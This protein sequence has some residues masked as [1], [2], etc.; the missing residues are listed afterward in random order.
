MKC[1]KN[2]SCQ[3]IED[4]PLLYAIIIRYYSTI[5]SCLSRR[6]DECFHWG[7]LFKLNTELFPDIGNGWDSYGE[8]LLKKGD[9][10][11]ALSA[12]KKALVIN[13]NI[14]SAQKAVKE[15]EK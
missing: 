12:Y 11:A 1:F 14:V 7:E 3:I 4:I 6:L 15:L 5:S 9:K 2:Q 8:A 13:P 10:K